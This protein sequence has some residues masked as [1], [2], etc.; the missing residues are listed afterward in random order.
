LKRSNKRDEK[1]SY[2]ED[3]QIQGAQEHNLKNVSITLPRNRF[4]VIT[5]VSGS[6]KSS[7]AFDVIFAEGQRKYMESLSSYARQFLRQAQKAKVENIIGLPPTIAIEQRGSSH[8]PRSTVATTTEIYDYL[9]LL[10]A[11]CATPRCWKT[12]KKGK[13]CHQEIEN[14]SVTKIVSSLM[15]HE[16][17]KLILM[18]PIVKGKKGFHKEV[19]LQL[20]KEGFVR[21]RVN[22]KILD[23]YEDLSDD[24]ENP[25]SLKRYETHSIEAVINRLVVK[26]A[27][28]TQILDSVET[29]LKIGAGSLIAEIQE[30]GAR[31]TQELLFS[32]HFACNEHPE[33]SLQEV[34]P[35]LFSFNSPFGSCKECSG[36]GTKRS[37]DRKLILDEEL[38]VAQGCM[39]AFKFL[40]SMYHRFYRRVLTG[41]CRRHNI[42]K[43]IPFKLLP[44]E[45][46]E[47]LLHGTEK[48]KRKKGF[49]GVLPLLQTR[50]L[51]T[52]N[53]KIRGKLEQLQTQSLCSKCE[54]ARIRK[55]ALH[56]FLET[57]GSQ[58]NIFDVCKMTVS[59]A[60]SF[61]SSLAFKKEKKLLA[62][63]ILKE[64]IA[65]LKFLSSVGLNYLNLNRLTASLSGGE[66]QRIRLATQI[67][68][69]LVGICYVLDEPTIGL[70]PRDNAQLIK[71]LKNLSSIGNTVIVVEHDEEVIRAADYLIDIGPG[72]GKHGGSI[73][74]SG[75]Y[76]E[77]IKCDSLTSKFLS[78]KESIPLPTI[79]RP[80]EKNPYLE[81]LGAK[82][83]NLKNLNVKIP[84]GGII[85]V[86][87]V[88]GSGK[89][90]LVNEVLLKSLK[91]K[92]LKSKE[93]AGV[94]DSLTGDEHLNRIIAVDQSPIGKTPRSNPATYTGLFDHI[95]QLF[96][97]TKQA[98]TL[99]YKP[100]RFSFNVKGGRCEECQGQG[101]KKIEMHFLP[102]CYIECESCEGTRYYSETLEIQYKG[103]NI[104]EV[105]ALTVEEALPFFDAHPNIK[106]ILQAMK[107]VGLDYIELGQS[108]TTLSGGE[109]QRVKL[110]SE[111]CKV[112]LYHVGK[113]PTLYILDEPTTG[114]HFADVRKLIEVFNNLADLGNTLVIIEHN[115]D[116]VKC[117]D[118]ILDLG[119]EGG[120]GGGKLMASGPPIK[121]AKVSKSLTAKFL[122]P[123]LK[124]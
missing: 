101:T 74:A 68:T 107:D 72:P 117:S 31:K 65:R 18:A 6:G 58:K 32:E 12:D 82:E 76:K 73:V 106:R 25:L 40:G 3:I 104:A 83:N 95:R 55:E 4:I 97:Q 15:S 11:R 36:L 85:C 14:Q 113:K 22:G 34:E 17:A 7:L 35:R 19:V 81:I 108:S 42:D 8:N 56:I 118:W 98:K 27:K 66:A 105:L 41:F 122:K 33:S 71:T 53:E 2:I 79:R 1:A 60:L 47:A 115:L 20:Q 38:S 50:Y 29:A 86:T 116:V 23:L 87:G 5:G 52:E 120:D 13:H 69:G 121:V 57:K 28:K 43:N 51:E 59:D 112:S 39:I 49:S 9:R 91:Q 102:E 90:T 89:S 63:P 80:V 94:C 93:R 75:T 48:E 88:S 92:L 61:F 77:F 114:L 44:N 62:E 10:F 16:D 78:K 110:A 24:S 30:K 99:G 124:K 100:G 84:L 64:V 111:L 123:L 67:G 119:P 26:K 45:Q 37:F 70:H 46:Q 109:A 103:K 54:G 21:A 96:S